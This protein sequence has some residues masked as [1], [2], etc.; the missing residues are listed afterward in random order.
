MC[1]L[2]AP[3]LTSACDDRESWLELVEHVEEG[4]GPR[5]PCTDRNLVSTTPVLARL[6]HL[7]LGRWAGSLNSR[8]SRSLVRRPRRQPR[9]RTRRPRRRPSL[10]LARRVLPPVVRRALRAERSAEACRRARRQR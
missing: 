10:A 7:A 2:V 1:G 5:S 6:R 4:S 3:P 9:E 8:E